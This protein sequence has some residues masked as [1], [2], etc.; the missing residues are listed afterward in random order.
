MQT[1]RSGHVSYSIDLLILLLA[2][3][4]LFANLDGNLLWDDEAETAL[5]GKNIIKYGLPLAYDG[6][7]LVSSELGREFGD[8]FVFRWSSW[9]DKYAAALSMH[10]FGET[11]IG[12]RLLF[13]IA[14]FASVI[15][16]YLTASRLFSSRWEARLAVLFYSTAMPFILHARQCRYYALSLLMTSL[17]LFFL[18]RPAMKT[19]HWAGFVAA[20]FLLFHSN[21]M[22]GIAFLAAVL[23]TVLVIRL[24]RPFPVK[25]YLAGIGAAFAVSLPGMLLYRTV[26][27]SDRPF[28]E[29]FPGNIAYYFLEINQ[30]MYP[31]LLAAAVAAVL[32]FKR[33]AKAANPSGPL[34][35]HRRLFLLG[36]AFVAF[37]LFILSF[38]PF[39]FM[40][41]LLPLFPVFALLLAVSVKLVT[42]KR[43]LVAAALSA[44]LILTNVLNVIPAMG[45]GEGKR[46]GVR[47]FLYEYAYE[48]THE[49]RGPIRGIVE[50]L[51]NNADADDVV[52][53]TYGD[54]PLKFYTGLEV[55]GGL[56]GEDLSKLDLDRVRWIIARKHV[57]TMEPGKDYSVHQFIENSFS[58]DDF[59]QITL[60]VPDTPFENREDPGQHLFR[61]PQGVP[62]VTIFKRVQ[63]P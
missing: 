3:L 17:A 42:G 36:S 45:F 33:G 22:I 29:S 25:E 14:A 26:G 61:T 16:L 24:I 48:L 21:Y 27:I 8:D 60:D 19:R 41:Y 15:V 1:S 12:A 34:G 10:L 28:T 52:L 13:V 35:D 53:I 50:F 23:S 43:A 9:G 54:L 47:S 39:S 18:L 4:L 31:V 44:L 63:A 11:T 58:P 62:P 57:V 59:T 49:M 38:A 56:T 51:N 5:L 46:A 32:V 7:N 20:S 55:H 2:A 40:R 30:Y 37:Y 6:K